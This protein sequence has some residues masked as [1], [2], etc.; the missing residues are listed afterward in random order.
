MDWHLRDKR[1]RIDRPLIMGIV[2]V[3]PDSFSD[4]GRVFS[5]NA[6]ILAYAGTLLDQGAD[7]LDVGGESTRPGASAV[8]EADEMK[9]VLPVVEQLAQRHPSAVISVDT[10]KSSVARAA[11]EAGAHIVNDVSGLRLDPKMGEVVSRARAGVVIMHSRGDVADMATFEHAEYGDIVG[12]V[13][14]ELRGQLDAA[15]AAGIP[16]EAIAIDPGL[17]FAKR[18]EHSLAILGALPDLVAWG[19]PIL[20]GASRKRFIGEITGVKDPA[21]RLH[22]T[23]GANV[24]ALARGARIFRVHDVRP[25]R[26]ALDVAWAVLTR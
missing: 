21:G 18:S 3:T 6:D 7:I 25:A 14:F 26:E 9:R 1:L 13:M 8:S 5:S 4:G 16:K 20:I 10:L 23:L 22:G 24:A 17:G 12:D 19:Y 15:R 11:L 2:N